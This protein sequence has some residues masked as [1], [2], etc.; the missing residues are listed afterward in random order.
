MYC[1]V[2]ARVVWFPSAVGTHS[3]GYL[4]LTLL[5]SFGAGS[6]AGAI[7]CSCDT[8]LRTTLFHLSTTLVLISIRLST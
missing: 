7:R 8:A 4:P 3:Q 6:L 5:Y 1:S 2:G